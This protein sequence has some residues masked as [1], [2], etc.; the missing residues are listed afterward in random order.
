MKRKIYVTARERKADQ[1]KGFL[2][3][4][5]VNIP[6][7]IIVQFIFSQMST[8]GTTK[9]LSSF[10]LVRDLILALP[11]LVNGVVLVLALVFR[12]QFGVG[13]IAFIAIAITVSTALSVL[14][15]A[16]CFVSI[17][18]ALFIGPLALG[19]FTILML[20]SLYIV[21]RAALNLV[22]RWLSS[23]ENT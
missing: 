15:V 13:Y 21:G 20:I 18:S 22:R 2:V 11:W 14:F 1:L 19:V 3:F 23:D 10:A 16:A 8:Q 7:W 4:P 12:P 5:I 17:L 6:L 9:D